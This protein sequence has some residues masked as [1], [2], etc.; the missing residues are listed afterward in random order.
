[1]FSL[2]NRPERR[3][4]GNGCLSQPLTVVMLVIVA[5]GCEDVIVMVEGA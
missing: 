4:L 1:M 2:S 3:T 5:P